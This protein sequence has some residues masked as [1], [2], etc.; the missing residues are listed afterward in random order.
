[1][2]L[3]SIGEHPAT[4]S[5]IQNP[6]ELPAKPP[7]VH[8]LPHHTNSPSAR[9]FPVLDRV[10]QPEAETAAKVVFTPSNLVQPAAPPPAGWADKPQAPP[11]RRHDGAGEFNRD[12]EL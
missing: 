10:S 7:F 11:S 5:R 3:T 12:G 4:T 1:M 6:P 9:G 8:E 2:Q